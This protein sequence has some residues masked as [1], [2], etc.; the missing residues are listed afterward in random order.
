MSDN[1]F[2]LCGPHGSGKTTLEKSLVS[3]GEGVVAP[4]LFSRSVK[5]D[6]ENE[7]YRQILKLGS[8]AIENF[9]YLKLAKENPDKI[10]LGN[11]CVYDCQAY[12]WVFK[13]RGWISQEKYELYDKFLDIN[14]QGELESPKA[15]VLNPGFE[16]V[17][18][19]LE[20]RWNGNGK[21]WREDDLDYLELAC[22][23]YEKFNGH[24]KVYYIDH[25]MNLEDKEEV[26]DV[27]CWMEETQGVLF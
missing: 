17:K 9:E 2:F 11:R 26:A 15:I 6:T 27:L 5:L 16:V 18:R 12:H 13:E 22:K 7:A 10:I 21:K 3:L 1:L 14:F 4:E 24:G 23:A 19:H 8:R 25:E 20:G